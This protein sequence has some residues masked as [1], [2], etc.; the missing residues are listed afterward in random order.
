MGKKTIT[1][2]YRITGRGAKAK[3]RQILAGT[4]ETLERSGRHPRDGAWEADNWNRDYAMGGW[5]T[6]RRGLLAAIHPA[7]VPLDEE[8]SRAQWAHIHER[9]P[10]P[11]K[12]GR[13]LALSEHY[14][15]SDMAKAFAVRLKRRVYV[16]TTEQRW[17]LL[18]LALDDGDYDDQRPG[19][20]YANDQAIAYYDPDGSYH[21]VGCS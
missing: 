16:V 21:F 10:D 11:E 6:D 18:V 5:P 9:G 3:M 8:Y 15:P 19:G 2:D 4:A 1:E 14:P 17:H 13:L 7:L 12:D 20:K